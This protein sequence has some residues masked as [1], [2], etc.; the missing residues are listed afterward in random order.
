MNLDQVGQALEQR[1]TESLE[2][3]NNPRFDHLATLHDLQGKDTGYLKA[4]TG[5]GIEKASSLS[6]NLLPMGLYFNINIIPEY[7]LDV[8][9]F[10]YE[11]MLSPQGSQLSIDLYPDI[12]PIMQFESFSKDYA[13]IEKIFDAAKA[14]T[15]ISF[16]PSRQAHMRALVS[17]FF[18]CG[19]GVAE[20]AL[21]A[22]E[23]YA[24]HYYDEW[25]HLFQQQ[26]QLTDAEA[27]QR[28]TR[29]D[30]IAST[31]MTLDPDRGMVV[32]IYGEEVTQAIQDATML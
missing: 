7:H 25:L 27:A 17:P 8:P 6:I 31:I 32:Q 18:L 16:E 30:H 10:T 22:V 20:H 21:D 12:D 4:Y 14:D 11:G 28:K 13:G 9:R 2:L 24:A 1:I 5:P 23:T 19:F 29:R 3:H 15:S 26:R